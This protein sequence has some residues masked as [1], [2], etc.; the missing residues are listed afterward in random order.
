MFGELEM[1][2]EEKAGLVMSRIFKSRLYHCVLSMVTLG[3]AHSMR[4]KADNWGTKGLG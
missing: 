1:Q 2:G 4:L 3:A